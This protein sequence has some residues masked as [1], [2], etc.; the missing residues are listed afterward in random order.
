MSQ[1]DQH[2]EEK[3]VF[4][5][6]RMTFS[7]FPKGKILKS[8]SPD[9]I[10]KKSIKYAFGVELTRVILENSTAEFFHEAITSI[11]EKKEEKLSIYKKKRLNE[12]W[13]IIYA[14]YLES[15]LPNSILGK[16]ESHGFQTDFNKLFLF[17]L[18]AKK[19]WEL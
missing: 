2:K 11:I 10:L 19:I 3:K 6:F 18:A 5:A 9:F 13:L 4:E 12:Y 14:P 8:E 15:I 1:L 7:D 16:I 17:D